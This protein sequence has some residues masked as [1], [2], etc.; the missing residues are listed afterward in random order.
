MNNRTKRIF[1]RLPASALASLLA[2]QTLT[3]PVLAESFTQPNADQ[4]FV[5]ET[6]SLPVPAA[7]STTEEAPAVSQGQIFIDN[8]EYRTLQDAVNAIPENGTGTIEITGNITLNSPARGLSTRRNITLKSRGAT[9]F[10]ITRGDSFSQVQD[11]ARSTYNP[12]MIEVQGTLTLENIILDDDSKT[13]GK[14]YAQ[15]GTDGKGQDMAGVGSNSETVQDAIVAMYDGGDQVILGNGAVLKNFGGMSAIRAS[16]GDVVMKSGSKISGSKLFTTR[17]DK[18]DKIEPFGAAGAIWLQGGKLMMEAGATIENVHGRAV[19]VDSSSASIAGTITNIMNN[20]FMWNGANAIHCRGNAQVTLEKT[21]RLVGSG[22]SDAEGVKVD[23]GSF[24]MNEG[25]QITNLSNIAISTASS[26]STNINGEITGIQAGQV[27]NLQGGECTIGAAGNIH[28]NIV[29]RSTIYFQSDKLHLY[30]KV[31]NNFSNDKSGGIEVNNNTYG[32]LTMYSGA[33]IKDN[34]GKEHG[35]GVMVC[36]GLFTME[37]G[38][39][40]GN[41]SGTAQGG[42]VNVRRGGCFIMEDGI[43]TG[44]VSNKEGGG[45]AYDGSETNYGKMNVQL[46]GGEVSNNIMNAAITPDPVNGSTWRDG[47]ANDLAVY[48]G[49]GNVENYVR[50]EPAVKMDRNAWLTP[51][52]GYLS[53]TDGTK[54]AL[55]NGSAQTELNKKANLLGF[56]EAKAFFYAQN[57]AGFEGSFS[58]LVLDNTKPVW[59]V[60]QTVNQDGSATEEAIQIYPAQAVDGKVSFS[61]PAAASAENGCI[62]GIVQPGNVKGSL[63]VAAN[64]TELV[65]GQD[66]YSIDYTL[67]FD[68]T[69]YGVNVGSVTAEIIS[70]LLEGNK[71]VAL[72][73]NAQGQWTGTFTGILRKENFKAGQSIF[74]SAIAT[75]TEKDNNTV[76]VYGNGVSVAMKAQQSGGNNRPSGGSGSG[77]S[78]ATGNV[79]AMH[80]LYNPNSG[81]HFYTQNIAERDYL[82]RI[83]WNYEGIGWYAPKNSSDPVYRLYNPNAGDHHYTLDSNEK[84]VLVSLGW[85]YEGIGWYSA[86]KRTGQP[87]HRQYNPN[88]VAGCHNF[89]VDT[90]ERDYLVSVG[91]HDE[92][93]AWHGVRVNK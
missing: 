70:P 41:V 32:E 49:A 86:N 28:H 48:N 77:S 44:N 92:D 56:A 27:L 18:K 60:T 83:G 90:K 38:T 10:T 74:T 78:S 19:Y 68:A 13:A 9:P 64:V 22:T 59:V 25:A 39:I 62:I 37:G 63:N 84:D 47:T 87:L 81:E 53:V 35:A 54:F 20:K 16:G 85:K 40:S 43:I 75:V 29:G 2:A 79:I 12:A 76:T 45:I 89:T 26:A 80:R 31:N 8:T 50:I 72:T 5:E 14:N 61:I 58:G 52:K 46:L 24:V 88:A 82:D 73:Q 71:N 36:R 30:G 1:K 51:F 91:W 42:G 3:L 21:G 69:E 17:G 67:T 4:S 15:A 65:E 33:E 93:I 66:S 6:S 7:D 11:T 55:A 57:E 23:G 34:Y